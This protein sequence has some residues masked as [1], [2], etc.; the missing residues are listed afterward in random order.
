MNLPRLRAYAALTLALSGCATTPPPLV[1]PPTTSS[2]RGDTLVLSLQL[3]GDARTLFLDRIREAFP[4]TSIREVQSFDDY[5]AAPGLLSVRIGLLTHGASF[6][7]GRWSAA[8]RLQL[9]AVD[10]RSE[11]P[12]AYG[13]VAS[14]SASRSNMWGE[15]SRNEA[16]QEA[17]T[18]AER[19]LILQLDSLG[20]RLLPHGVPLVLSAAS[21]EYAPF[22]RPG[23]AKLTGQAFLTTRGGDVKLGAGRSVT[24]D[25][26]TTYSRSWYRRAGR[27]VEQFSAMPPSPLFAT[28]RR[29]TTGDAEGRFDFTGLPPG[30]Y[31][32]RSV[33]TWEVPGASGLERQGG[34]VAAV[35]AIGEGEAKNVILNDTELL[36]P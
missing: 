13:S 21:E 5:S 12:L 17:F 7:L 3:A 32:V 23:T 20:A 11:P 22:T 36:L 4:G 15:R 34:V 27:S 29:T 35:V 6:D 9:S 31:L 14:A 1:P 8:T 30:E 33:V 28:A 25:P 10:R 24:L 26:L 16:L 19:A 2:L 18:T